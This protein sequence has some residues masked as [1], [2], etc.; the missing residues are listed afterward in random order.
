MFEPLPGPVDL[1]IANLPYV[2]SADMPRTGNAPLSFEPPLALDGGEDGL[3]KIIRLCR[4]AGGRLNPRGALLLELGQGQARPVI[5]L[6]GSLFPS[7]RIEATADLGGIERMV[8]V[9]LTEDCPD[10]KISHILSQA[11]HEEGGRAE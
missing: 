10:D 5:D 3:S 4:Q 6:L 8:S 1:I 11:A 7:A 9:T 2:S